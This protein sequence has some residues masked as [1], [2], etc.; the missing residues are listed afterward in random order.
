MK[1]MTILALSCILHPKDEEEFKILLQNECKQLDQTSGDSDIKWEAIRRSVGTP[2]QRAL[3]ATYLL[4]YLRLREHDIQSGEHSVELR[5]RLG[6]STNFG[7]LVAESLRYLPFDL[8][9]HL[10]PLRL[11]LDPP[12]ALMDWATSVVYVAH[13]EGQCFEKVR[14]ARLNS[15]EYEHPQDRQML[16]ALRSTT[17]FDTVVRKFNEYG[18]EPI[19][20]IRYTGSN[21][22]VTQNNFPDL[23]RKL[24]VAC[25]VLEVSQIPDLYLQQGFINAMTAGVHEPVIVIDSGSV[26][27]LTHDELMFL[28]G[29]ELGH[30]KSQHLLYHNMSLVLPIIGEIIGQATLGI[31]GLLATGL[32]VALL[33]WQRMSEFTADRAGLL[34]NQNIN[35]ACKLLM[36]IAGAPPK[37][38]PQLNIHDFIQ[39]SKEFTGLDVLGRNKVAKFVSI[40]GSD[41]P[42][43][44]MRGAE[45]LQW[46]EGGDYE[47]VMNRGAPPTN[48]SNSVRHDP[49][50][51]VNKPAIIQRRDHT[52]TE[53]PSSLSTVAEEL[54]G[55]ATSQAAGLLTKFLDRR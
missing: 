21:I 26:S 39:Q 44:V 32:T 34:C 3:L 17:G 5:K 4:L 51:A 11:V 36:K 38:Y 33:N 22:K 25:D 14:I 12:Q 9:S 28:I 35:A 49:L 13:T 6:L 30:I 40:L 37:F 18:V 53:A 16:D 7:Q 45:L 46:V 31:G 29:H 19:L 48:G 10:S 23:Y 8:S 20:R 1:R 43:T 47:K 15:T 50:D 54:L 52:A 55:K 41:H 42:W 24:R 27:L 2:E